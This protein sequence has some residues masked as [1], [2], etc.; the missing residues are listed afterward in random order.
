MK[1]RAQKKD[2]KT[3]KFKQEL[4]ARREQLLQSVRSHRQDIPDRG[5]QG[6]TGDSSDHA[7]ADYATEL[8][9]A[10]LEKQA[11]NLEEVELALQKIESGQYGKCE[12]CNKQIIQKRLRAIAWARLCHDCQ[13]NQD[14]INTERRGGVNAGSWRT[15]Q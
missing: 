8:F 10:L 2:E 6:T 7:A 1:S 15:N 9:G 14:R 5:L 13:E 11:G 4:L 12:L 3:D